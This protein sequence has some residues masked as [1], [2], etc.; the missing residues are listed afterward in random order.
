MPAIPGLGPEPKGSLATQSSQHG[1]GHCQ[2]KESNDED[3]PMSTS[4]LLNT[5]VL[6][7]TLLHLLPAHTC[8]YTCTHTPQKYTYIHTDTKHTENIRRSVWYPGKPLKFDNSGYFVPQNISND[9]RVYV[10]FQPFIWSSH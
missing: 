4:I 2:E 1:K 8:K 7:R 6:P 10:F 3:I 5:Y 9:S